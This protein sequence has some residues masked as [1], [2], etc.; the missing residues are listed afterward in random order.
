MT[1]RLHSIDPLLLSPFSDPLE[2]LLPTIDYPLSSLHNLFLLREIHLGGLS[3]TNTKYINTERD[4]IVIAIEQS[5]SYLVL[6]S[7][8]NYTWVEIPH[9]K[10]DKWV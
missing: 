10:S 2:A 1:L 5:S 6:D 3:Q 9:H 4:I 7:C 8:L